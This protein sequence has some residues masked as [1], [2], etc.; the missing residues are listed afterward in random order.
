M[1][2]KYELPPAEQVALAKE[3]AFRIGYTAGASGLV[4]SRDECPLHDPILRK[5]WRE[6][7]DLGAGKGLKI[8]L[9]KM[10]GR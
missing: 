1:K 3:E 2:T 8:A 4:G 10:A 5:R 7:F 9:P 6:G